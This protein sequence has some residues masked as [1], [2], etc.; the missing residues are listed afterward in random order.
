MLKINAIFFIILK[1]VNTYKQYYMDLSSNDFDNKIYPFTQTISEF[2]NE[3]IEIHITLPGTKFPGLYYFIFDYYFSNSRRCTIN[4]LNKTYITN[5]NKILIK[6]NNTD[7][8]EL[9]AQLY[10]SSTITALGY[11]YL[12]NFIFTYSSFS[13]FYYL[14]NRNRSIP[15]NYND[16]FRIILNITDFE[17]Y[18]TY[19]LYNTFY[20]IKSPDYKLCESMEEALQFNFTNYDGQLFTYRS[21]VSEFQKKKDKDNYLIL[22]FVGDKNHTNLSD[23]YGRSYA[24][25][26]ILEDHPIYKFYPEIPSIIIPSIFVIITAVLFFKFQNFKKTKQIKINETDANKELIEK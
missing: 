26:A 13:Y 11:D 16:D 7:K 10:G 22:H 4:V 21:N 20:S 5:Y 2:P 9:N 15:Y 12:I 1:L 3:G 8:F 6:L 18:K 17:K 23:K 14:V 24:F 19:Y 25:M